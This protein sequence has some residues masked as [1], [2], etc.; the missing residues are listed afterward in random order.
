MSEIEK[1]LNRIKNGNATW[2][3]FSDFLNLSNDDIEPFFDIAYK[4][5]KQ[6]FNNTLKIYNPT[7]KFPAI[8][9]T[10]DK[11]ALHC[12][13][14]NEKYLK[15]M[16]PIL[17]NL[18]LEL[19]LMKH[20]ENGGVGALISGGCETDGSVPLIQF[21]D[22]IKKVKHKTNLII[23]THTGLLHEPT[24]QKL[25]EAGV[26]IVSFDINLD[27]EI[28]REI[29][30]LDKNL[31]EYKKAII[32]LQ[33]YNLNI[34]PHICIGLYYGKLHKELDSI[35]F[36]LESEITPSLIVLIALIPPK[37]SI[38]FQT[39]MALDIAKIVALIRFLFPHTEISLGC[40]RPRGSIKEELEKYAIKAGITR[41]EIPSKQTLK[42]LK[43]ENPQVKLK[44][45]SACC[46][47]P[48]KYENLAISKYSDIKRYLN[49]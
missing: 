38:K 30:H 48:E 36:I 6:N 19:F 14:C 17:N 47:I 10:G 39:P 41:I 4:L 27:E 24:A 23:N 5:T 18:D 26:D 33:R 20:Y 11:C 35:K 8:S 1:L 45:F 3:D 21:L 37:N 46:A 34:V 28:L 2:S 25:A 44:Y 43:K 49:L 22:T 42:W 40:M 31:A 9:I 13:H 16:K 32:L 7:N 12:E 15:G 29:Y